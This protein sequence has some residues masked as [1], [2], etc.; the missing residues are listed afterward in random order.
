MM[1]GD[2]NKKNCWE[3]MGCGRHPGGESEEDLGVCP[4]AVERKLDGIHEGRN[5]GRTCWVVAGTMCGGAVQGTFARK[6][7][8]CIDCRFYRAVSA[9][10]GD[11]F[12]S[13]VILMNL[14]GEYRGLFPK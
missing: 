5:A 10:E 9:E 13:P 1:K 11:R 3:Y 14:L 12:L 6:C 8:Q 2:N 7:A 4:A